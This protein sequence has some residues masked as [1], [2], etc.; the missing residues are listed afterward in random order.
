MQQLNNIDNIIFDL[1]GVILDLDIQKAKNELRRLGL[2]EIDDLFGLGH[3]G[4]FFMEHEQ[5]RISD[6]DFVGEI[7]RRLNGQV[8][9]DIIRAAWNS[10]LLRFPPQRIEF[11]KRLSSK[12]RLFLF[13][14]TNGIHLDAFRKLY[15]TS[16][17][18]EAL[19]DLFEKAYYSH[20]MRLRKPDV[21]SFQFII[22]DKTLEPARTLFI[23]DAEINVKG[24][25]EA[26]L[27]GLHLK[28]GV[29][30]EELLGTE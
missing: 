2:A 4:S 17:N 12:Y 24:A 23:D 3:A 11:L 20:L 7:S 13:S 6:D 28:P 22:N 26:G 18:G 29:R 15:Q 14:N 8:S 27:Q 25:I 30:V 21:K 5:G 16:F 1:G 19:D 10:M 9:N